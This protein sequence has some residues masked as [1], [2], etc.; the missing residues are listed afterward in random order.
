MAANYT[1][2]H[3][4]KDYALI[5]RNLQEYVLGL[6][7]GA[8][9]KGWGTGSVARLLHYAEDAADGKGE[10][11]AVVLAD[12][13][14]LMFQLSDIWWLDG[15]AIVEYSFFRYKPGGNVDDVYLAMEQLAR[16]YGAKQIVI[17]SSASVSDK[18]YARLLVRQGFTQGSIQ[19]IKE[20]T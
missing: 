17:A 16:N 8:K 13:H 6:T 18:A 19:F 2:V 4:H 5:R 10:F 1:Y 3:Q 14:I 15:D 12:T 7:E 20:I 9:A 11:Q